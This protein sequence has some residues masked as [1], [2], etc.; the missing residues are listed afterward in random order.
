MEQLIFE[1]A[2]LSSCPTPIMFMD[3]H[4]LGAKEE[5]VT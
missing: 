3:L 4:R 5:T 2:V 1:D